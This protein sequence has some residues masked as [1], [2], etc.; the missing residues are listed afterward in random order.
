MLLSYELAI[1]SL[2]AEGKRNREIAIDLGT[3]EHVIKNRLCAIYDKLGF[4]NRTELALWWTRQRFDER[5]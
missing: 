5:N 1:A 4:W 2:V 3:T